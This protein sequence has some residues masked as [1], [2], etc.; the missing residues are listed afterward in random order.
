VRRVIVCNKEY[1]LG[2]KTWVEAIV[3]FLKRNVF[4]EVYDEGYSPLSPTKW[5]DQGLPG[6]GEG[7][8]C[9]LSRVRCEHERS[10]PHIRTG[11]SS[12][13]TCTHDKYNH[14]RLYGQSLNLNLYGPNPSVMMAG[15]HR[16]DKEGECFVRFGH[17]GGLNPS[18]IIVKV[19]TCKEGKSFGFGSHWP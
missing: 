8:R 3:V 2:T 5:D 15:E 14:S 1:L 9:W 17:G 4:K 10:S 16:E 7:L 18:G 12:F 11:L 13:T 19:R 6:L